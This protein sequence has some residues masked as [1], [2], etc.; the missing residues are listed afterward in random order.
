M[1]YEKS[2][3]KMKEVEK[4]HTSAALLRSLRRI[5][6][7]EKIAYENGRKSA[8]KKGPA[9]GVFLG[10]GLRPPGRPAAARSAEDMD[11]GTGA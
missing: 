4:K 10:A 9:K 3:E 1:K 2:Y 5:S 8:Q 11:V 7:D 6:T